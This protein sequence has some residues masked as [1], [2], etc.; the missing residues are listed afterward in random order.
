MRTCVLAFTLA[1]LVPFTASGALA[2]P[3]QNDN[4]GT[5][6]DDYQDNLGIDYQP[7]P[8]DSPKTT[9]SILHDAA[10]QAMVLNRPTAKATSPRA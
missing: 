4:L 10:G 8:D 3:T 9:P 1:V 7:W 2:A 5:W 6:L